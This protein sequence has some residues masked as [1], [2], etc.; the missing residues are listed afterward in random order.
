M[1]S[2]T[3]KGVSMPVLQSDSNFSSWNRTFEGVARQNGL[4]SLF[5][6]EEAI[7]V[8]PT[9]PVKPSAR[10]IQ[11][12]P[13][14]WR[15]MQFDYKFDIEEYRHQETKIGEALGLLTQSLSTAFHADIFAYGND[16]K[17]AYNY[18]KTQFK[19]SDWQ[20]LTA[21][22]DRFFKVQ[23]NKSKNVSRFVDDLKQAQS[24]IK[25]AKG[26]CDD[27]TLLARISDNLPKDYD[28]WVLNN[29]KLA[30]DQ[31]TVAD[32]VS[33]LL[34]IE[35]LIKSRKQP[36]RSGESK[37]QGQK[38]AGNDSRPQ[39]S[40]CKMIG[41][42]VDTCF[43]LY[44]DLKA[45][46]E[47]RKKEK[48]KEKEKASTNSNSNSDPKD[49]G[50][51]DKTNVKVV[52]TLGALA[53]VDPT[54]LQLKRAEAQVGVGT[55][56]SHPHIVPVADQ[57][58]QV[59]PPKG[60]QLVGGGKERVSKVSD[61]PLPRLWR[62]VQ[63]VRSHN[64]V[65]SRN[66][67]A[68]LFPDDNS[69]DP[70]LIGDRDTS[71][72]CQDCDTVDRTASYAAVCTDV[73]RDA[74][75]Y[76]SGANA[77][78]INNLDYVISSKALEMDVGTADGGAS[79]KVLSEVV[80]Q[81]PL[82]SR[83]GLVQT[84]YIIRECL[85]VPSSRCN[86]ISMSKLTQAKAAIHG[87]YGSGF[88]TLEHDGDEVGVCDEKD[89]LYHI[90]LADSTRVPSP[91]A[92]RLA[93]VVD[94][95]DK[96]WQWH[97]RLGHPTW[98][99]MLWLLDRSEGMVDITAAQIKAKYGTVCPVCATTKATLKVPREP[100]RR[101]ATRV[102]ERLHVDI[103]GR[104]PVVGIN[105]SQYMLIITD[106]FSRYSWGEAAPSRENMAQRAINMINKIHNVHD[107]HTAL[108]RL[109]QEIAN[110]EVF[111][112]WAT[113]EG[114][115]IEGTVPYAH[116]QNGVAERKNRTIR[117][118]TSVILAQGNMSHIILRGLEARNQELLAH[119]RL[120]EKM[121]PWAMQHA[122][123]ARNRL[124][125]RSNK[126]KL[127]PWELVHGA[128]PDLSVEKT[129]GSRVY[130]TV[131]HETRGP[132]LQ[133]RAW[134]GHY[135]GHET[136]AI[137]L[138][139]D[140]VA[141]VV[142]R[143]PPSRVAERE[144]VDDEQDAP[145]FRDRMPDF[146]QSDNGDQDSHEKDSHSEDV[147]DVGES[148]DSIQDDAASD[149]HVPIDELD[150]LLSLNDDRDSVELGNDLPES[151][152][153]ESGSP[154]QDPHQH[155]T[156]DQPGLWETMDLPADDCDDG[157]DL[158]G[159][160]VVMMVQKRTTGD[161]DEN[162]KK[163]GRQLSAPSKSSKS[164]SK[165]TP[166]VDGE[167]CAQ[168]GDVKQRGTLLPTH[169]GSL[170]IPCANKVP[171]PPSCTLCGNPSKTYYH[172]AE[173]KICGT[174]R[175]Q[176]LAGEDADENG[177][178]K[179]CYKTTRLMLPSEHGAICRGCASKIPNPTE[180]PLCG[181]G[182][183]SWRHSPN[184]KICHNCA[185]RT[186]RQSKNA[187]VT[188][189][190]CY[191][192]HHLGL[193][194]DSGAP[195]STCQDAQESCH[196][197]YQKG[198]Q[199]LIDKCDPCARKG[200]RC[201][202]G[203]PCDSCKRYQKCFP[204]GT[205]PPKRCTSC[206]N[207]IPYDC[208]G[209][210]P[211]QICL[212]NSH[213]KYC[214]EFDFE[215]LRIIRYPAAEAEV[216]ACQG[217]PNIC[218]ACWTLARKEVMKAIKRSNSKD[219]QAA[220]DIRIEKL[221]A[222]HCNDSIDH[223]P[224][225]SCIKNKAGVAWCT[226]DGNGISIKVPTAPWYLQQTSLG[227]EVLAL[228]VG[229]R[230]WT[231]EEIKSALSK[232]GRYAGRYTQ[233]E[234]SDKKLNSGRRK[235][236]ERVVGKP[237]TLKAV[238]GYQQTSST[239]QH[240]RREAEQ[241]ATAAFNSLFPHGH[242]II[243]TLGTGLQCAFYAMINS[244]QDMKDRGV[245]VPV[246]SLEDLQEVFDDANFQAQLREFETDF[247]EA[248]RQ[249]YRVDQAGAVLNWWASIY[250]GESLR[251]GW[252]VNQRK[253]WLT[254]FQ[255]LLESGEQPT[256]VFIHN[257][258]TGAEGLNHFSGLKPRPQKPVPQPVVD[259]DE[260]D[261]GEN[262]P[263]GDDDDIT[264]DS[265]KDEI[266]DLGD[267]SVRD[268]T[269]QSRKRISTFKFTGLVK[270][271]DLIELAH[272]PPPE[273]R[274]H[275]LR[276]P[277][278]EE[279]VASMDAEY[280]SLLENN[281]LFEIILPEGKHAITVK[282]VYKR[283]LDEEGRI[284]KWKSRIVARGFQ[285]IEGVDYHESYAPVAK[286]SSYRVLFAVSAKLGWHIL[287]M[288]AVTAFLNS[289]LEE[290]VYI[291]SIPGYPT[292]KGHVYQLKKALYGLKQASRAWYLLLVKALKDMG[293]RTSRYDDCMFIHD[294]ACVY[295]LLW[296]DDFIFFG[297]DK[298]LITDLQR[299]LSACFKM[300]DMGNCSWVLGM[301]IQ[302]D[303]NGIHV[304]QEQYITQRAQKYKYYEAPRVTTPMNP[305]LRLAKHGNAEPN[306]AFPPPD[307]VAL[308]APDDFRT[309]Y[310]SINGTLNYSATITRPDMAYAV[311]VTSRFNSNPLQ[312][313]M[314]ALGQVFEYNL[315]TKSVGLFFHKNG[316]LDLAGW[317]DSDFAGCPDSRKSTTGWIFLLGGTAV[318]WKSKRQTITTTS[319]CEAEYVALGDAAK[320]AMYLKNLLNDLRIPGTGPF[321]S[322]PIRIDNDAA[323]SVATS[324][325]QSSRLKHLEIAYHFVREKIA[326]EE[327][328]LVRVDSE[329]NIADMLTKALHG[330][331]LEYLRR[332]A[333]MQ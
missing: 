36:S 57:H 52:R 272:A 54:Y 217:N 28:D 149:F 12:D 46:F 59:T 324:V 296:V 77:H 182:S 48:D 238:A 248:E 2:T 22:W 31:P 123:W 235:D 286:H 190:P 97:F 317:V 326:D 154:F 80:I 69:S 294:E 50:K 146:D 319:T 119:T 5:T 205:E 67:F 269:K 56:T 91:D 328:H 255:D 153:T 251:L 142:K 304:S 198:T 250:Y 17:G 268:T 72:Q 240:P 42:S 53:Y 277:D 241:E 191:R 263:D 312:D 74:W 246:P 124:P 20:R 266:I 261:D 270:A 222:L 79:M 325:G 23:F 135:V 208:N 10:E 155:V 276:A 204:Y 197:N 212:N 167:Q 267:I 315:N 165:L 199:R 133:Q 203:T 330:P 136:E 206:D 309:L 109:D 207:T 81:L 60:W 185:V 172:S 231:K 278:A 289:E 209:E 127:T 161:G 227:Q 49:K 169:E 126:D 228:D 125:S 307:V 332:L 25:E 293:W 181:K 24:D 186:L 258:S 175:K 201:N 145:S 107:A 111:R 245:N 37:S 18:I 33:S 121:W 148:E 173:G 318:S 310:Q 9:K 64:D 219:S 114:I 292:K 202:G 45:V 141:D 257:N 180:C 157:L 308:S 210:R 297:P 87:T 156:P 19:Q 3:Y 82:I 152:L 51:D 99:Y 166:I 93:M 76:D 242:D 122:I 260:D 144:A 189:K 4:W 226:R 168:C 164:A 151:D 131:P 200:K 70:E 139:Y 216:K 163:K 303:G 323:H 66:Y 237:Q 221:A 232:G 271:L 183:N 178:C 160:A 301:H 311:S 35:S 220:V 274:A 95:Q 230:S 11:P 273:Y 143:A 108:I 233:S 291:R 38:T 43:S 94:F 130:V 65:K 211:C 101:R 115:I 302:Q 6:G 83:D 224:C 75:I 288:D 40:N 253:P 193:T 47:A 195:C 88:I 55:Y 234:L 177:F 116:Y 170:C 264:D 322:I 280:A 39:C 244:L 239:F 299:R 243:P 44:P 187:Q 298:V 225:V 13:E 174:C 102:G 134:P 90:R 213:D 106:D 159:N 29:I 314:D 320:E 282:W 327:I 129:W 16:M 295:M 287:Q 229:F 41:H 84:N 1:S 96:V 329:H 89:G 281:V 14:V 256:Y 132:K 98:E 188:K 117:D 265:D 196:Y 285:Q 61:G 128:V 333:G 120:P 15:G 179:L 252:I 162:P 63:G 184:G 26:N 262:G 138:V 62:G 118:T 71:L 192:C 284:S 110:T 247:V 103:W 85:F 194:C 290:E 283:K 236:A 259:H 306:D 86:L 279:W 8:K 275:A 92:D 215:N 249:N 171:N 7:L 34:A 158:F 68:P 218:R 254:P 305:K 112:D 105:N 300:T 331:R 214:S 100:A 140:P 78:I 104:Y 21:A 32:T 316:E 147:A 150:D 27:A 113:A 176:R 137:F 321:T 73:F 58:S 30:K 223:T 313:H